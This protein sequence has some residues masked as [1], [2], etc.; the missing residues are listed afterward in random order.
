[1]SLSLI[2]SS[3]NVHC[4]VTGTFGTQGWPLPVIE[5]VYPKSAEA[6]KWFARFLIQGEIFTKL[7]KYVKCLL[8]QPS[9][10]IKTWAKL[11]PR[12]EALLNALI[13]RD[14]R[15]K[16]TLHDI[17]KETPQCE[18]IQFSRLSSETW[19]TFS[20]CFLRYVSLLLFYNHSR[21]CSLY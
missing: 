14:C 13:S 2:I 11:Q 7:K 8:S 20:Y 15:T 5:I 3:G 4:K 17:W 10:M 18:Y 21:M 16:Q 9:V 19:F 1:M 12:T 6:Y